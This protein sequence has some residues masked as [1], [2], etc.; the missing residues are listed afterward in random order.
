MAKSKAQ[1]LAAAAYMA[2]RRAAIRTA[3]AD[4]KAR[5]ETYTEPTLALVF[6][7]DGG[8]CYL[9]GHH[10]SPLGAA[11]KDNNRPTMDHRLALSNGGLHTL[12]NISLACYSCNRQKSNKLV[13]EYSD[14]LRQ[15]EE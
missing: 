3:K 1:M 10:C 8:V 13:T 2:R 4:A 6:E 11:H 15:I 9:C 14:Q 12:D 7:R 5:G